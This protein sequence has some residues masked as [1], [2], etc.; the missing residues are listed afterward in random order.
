MMEDGFFPKESKDEAYFTLLNGAEKA[1]CLCRGT[2][3]TVSS[4]LQYFLNPF[5]KSLFAGL[6]SL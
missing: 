2:M 3:T 5:E 6:S 1:A 4:T